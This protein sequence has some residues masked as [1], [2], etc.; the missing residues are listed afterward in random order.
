MKI[1]KYF[2]K[3]NSQGAAMT[4]ASS[5]A[6]RLRI[7]EATLKQLEDADRKASTASQPAPSRVARSV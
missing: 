1:G 6:R 4:V 7:P 3:D 5:E 2:K